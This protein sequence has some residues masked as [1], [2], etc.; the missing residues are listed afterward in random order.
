[1]VFSPS[2]E[3]KVDIALAIKII[4]EGVY[5]GR[6][7]YIKDTCWGCYEYQGNFY[8]SLNHDENDVWPADAEDIEIYNE[9]PKTP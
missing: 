3:N 4:D 5:L 9:M 8:I 1:M 2:H 7:Y 6:S